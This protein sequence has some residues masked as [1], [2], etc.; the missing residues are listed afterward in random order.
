MLDG[1]GLAQDRTQAHDH[2]G[3]QGVGGAGV[4]MLEC[5]GTGAGVQGWRGAGVVGCRCAGVQVCRG[6]GVQ[7]QGCRGGEVQVWWG[8]GVQ[9][10]RCAGVQAQGC[11]GAA[12]GESTLDVLVG[13][14]DQLLDAGQQVGHDH[15]GGDGGGG[16]EGD[17]NASR[18]DH[19]NEDGDAPHLLLHRL[20]QGQAEVLHLVG[21]GRAHLGTRRIRRIDIQ[22]NQ[23]NR[24]PRESKEPG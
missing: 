18:S 11:G 9:V 6:A 17:E 21:R 10:C 7:A 20:V 1:I 3:V 4:L 19:D 5:G 12:P 8:A 24:D 13:V 2:A 23:E 15:L 16:D 22:E 14:G